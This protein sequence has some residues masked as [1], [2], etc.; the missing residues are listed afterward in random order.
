MTVQKVI[1]FPT[2][3]TDFPMNVHG[4]VKGLFEVYWSTEFN[5]KEIDNIWCIVME[6]IW[7][8]NKISPIFWTFLLVMIFFLSKKANWEEFWFFAL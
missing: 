3:L 4:M 6:E 7:N 2:F 8:N 5:V 1:L